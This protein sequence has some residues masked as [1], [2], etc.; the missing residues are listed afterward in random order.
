MK[1][2]LIFG[3]TRFFGKKLVSLLLEKG[4]NVTIATRGKTEDSFSDGVNRIVIDRTKESEAWETI[5]KN[6]YDVVYDNICYSSNEA[7]L[8]AKYLDGRTKRYIL[9]STLSVY[10]EKESA[11]T[12]EDFVPENYQLH[13]V[14]LNEVSYGEGK[15][16]T[17]A[18]L[19]QKTELPVVAVRFPIVLGEDDYTERLLWHVERVEKEE[20]IGLPNL[21]AKMSFINSDEA[22]KWLYWVGME[23]NETGTFNV[24]AN[25]EWEMGSLLRR[26][27]SVVGKKANVVVPTNTENQSPFGIPNS[28]YMTNEKAAKLGFSFSD[29]NDWLPKLIEDLHNK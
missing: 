20:E 16:Q 9:T 26:I 10:D 3:G 14:D 4:V 7:A 25:N 17:E 21:S 22:A 2:V 28:W 8:A 29:L 19:F 13:M 12:E 5:A 15:R 6:N 1:N 11:N 18:Y 24:C 23:C 27:E